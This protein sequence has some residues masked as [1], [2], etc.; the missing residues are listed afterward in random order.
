MIKYAWTK[1][2]KEQDGQ[3]SRCSKRTIWHLG[4]R[5]YYWEVKTQAQR[6]GRQEQDGFPG[7]SCLRYFGLLLLLTEEQFQA[8]I[9]YLCLYLPL[10]TSSF[11]SSCKMLIR[12]STIN[13]HLPLYLQAVSIDGCAA[14]LSASEVWFFAF[15]LFSCPG[16]L[17][18][19]HCQSV[20][21]SV[22][23]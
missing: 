21:Q 10:P 4:T 16:Q 23:N 8:I 2:A 3:I 6:S 15:C 5:C 12:I 13:L 9:M 17:N 18:R 22:I 7:R 14:R 11:F 20:S 1:Q 19:W